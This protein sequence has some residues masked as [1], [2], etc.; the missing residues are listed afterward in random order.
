[1]S[2]D[3]E[4]EMV[5]A[6]EFVPMSLELFAIPVTDP[7]RSKEFYRAMGWHC[8][9]DYTAEDAYRVVQFTP[10]G[11]SC[12]IMFG[13]NVS[14]A[15]PGSFRGA[16]LIV[17][18]LTAARETLLR[19]GIAVGEPFHDTA[20]IFHHAD[21]KFITPGLN[22]ARQSYASYATFSD[23]DGN[24]WTLQEVNA[25]LTPDLTPGDTRFTAQLVQVV[26]G[27]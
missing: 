25:R 24:Q 15:V 21:G 5:G 6:A 17:N 7:D 10:P 27:G 12:S 20:G 18:D 16:H 2:G 9:L 8:D 26:T 14:D 13:N 4:I 19:R 23:P 1:M 3:H 22:P 11:S